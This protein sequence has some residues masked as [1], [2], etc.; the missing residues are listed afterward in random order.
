[1]NDQMQNA[2]AQLIEKANSGI[3]ASV[4]FL[5][6]EIPDVIHQLIVYKI[7]E[8]SIS[9]VI[10]AVIAAIS[11]FVVFKFIVD[12]NKAES[13]GQSNWAHDGSRYNPATMIG[14]FSFVV[15]GMSFFVFSLVFVNR[16]FYAAKIYF[17]PKIWLIEYA[18]SLAK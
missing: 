18:S 7:F 10:S 1:M 15:C 3:D 4:G 14:C 5:S 8:S 12:Y 17:A 6:Q 2:L 9:A 11:F 16:A 13:G